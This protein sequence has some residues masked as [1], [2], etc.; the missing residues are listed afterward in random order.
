MIFV[1][2]FIAAA[3]YS[4][5]LKQNRSQFVAI[6]AVTMHVVTCQ[7]C[8]C[9]C[10]ECAWCRLSGVSQRGVPL[11]LFVSS[12]ILFKE[13]P[14]NCFTDLFSIHCSLQCSSPY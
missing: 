10:A 2:D 3:V 12:C 4:L 5:A 11:L 13:I 14:E 1:C 8:A 7:W 6:E 9:V